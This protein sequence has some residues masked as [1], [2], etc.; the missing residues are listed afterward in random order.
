MGAARDEQCGAP[1]ARREAGGA[2]GGTSL[3]LHGVHVEFPYAPY[4]CQRAYMAKV[5]EALQAR[6]NALLESPT[7]TGKTLC[8][9]CAA[10]AWRETAKARLQLGRYGGDYR[11]RDAPESVRQKLRGASGIGGGDDDDDGNGNG[12][13]D[14]ASML[15]AIVA[16]GSGENGATK[17]VPRIIYLSRTHSQLTQVMR[18]LSVTA[19]ARSTRVLVMGA[20]QH[21]CIHPHVSQIASSAQQTVRCNAMTRSRRCEFYV[22]AEPHFQR[23]PHD[24]LDSGRPRDIE[25]MVAYGRE[26]R[27]CPYFL[28]RE[29]VHEA[30]LVLMPY[31]YV[32]DAKSRRA[33][34]MEFADDILIF[35]EAHN[36]ESACCEHSSFDLTALERRACLDALDHLAKNV[37]RYREAGGAGARELD[38]TD[39]LLVRDVVQAVDE[40][41]RAAAARPEGASGDGAA[42]FDAAMLRVRNVR[43]A[44]FRGSFIQ[45]FFQVPNFSEPVGRN[46][47]EVVV[48]AVELFIRTLSQARGVADIA[49][50]SGGAPHDYINN[51]N[52]AGDGDGGGDGDAAAVE[53]ALLQPHRLSQCVSALE[54]F[55]RVLQLAF[56]HDEHAVDRYFRI[57]VRADEAGAAGGG[58]GDAE[59]MAA[60]QATGTTH[61]D[62]FAALRRPQHGPRGSD[63][64][65]GGRGAPAGPVLSFWC[66]F[67]GLNVQSLARARSVI[68]TSGTLSPLDSFAA[69]MGIA[70]PVRLQNTHVIGAEQLDARVVRTGPSG[71]RL[72]GTYANRHNAE[73][74]RDLGMTLV[75][76]ARLAPGGMLVFFSS[77]GAMRVFIE[78]WQSAPRQQPQQPQQ[79]DIVRRSLWDRLNACKKVVVEPRA[80]NEFQAV[81][82]RYRKLVDESGGACLFAV[83]RG[84]IGEGLDFADQYG[85]AVV[86]AGVPFPSTTD[87][88]VVL[89][90]DFLDQDY[91]HQ[92]RQQRQQQREHRASEGG[93][94]VRGEDWYVQQS[95]RAANQAIGRVIR[96]CNDYGA[97]LLCDERYQARQRDLPR[98][99]LHLERRHDGDG[100]HGGA[101]AHA[102][103]AATRAATPAADSAGVRVCAHFGE[104][105]AGLGAFFRSD[106][107]KQLAR[108][109]RSTPASS[110]A[111]DGTAAGVPKRTRPDDC[112]TRAHADVSGVA[113][114]MRVFVADGGGGGEGEGDEGEGAVAKRSRTMVAK[115]ACS[116]ASTSPTPYSAALMARL[117]RHLG[118]ARYREMFGLLRQYRRVRKKEAVADETACEAEAA[119]LCAQ[120]RDLVGV[121]YFAE[122][123]MFLGRRPLGG[124]ERPEA[125][126]TEKEK[127]E[128]EEEGRAHE[129]RPSCVHSI[130]DAATVATTTTTTDSGEMCVFCLRASVEPRRAPCQHVGCLRCWRAALVFR[131]QCPRCGRRTTEH[132]LVG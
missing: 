80:A 116:S 21:L 57:C 18:E 51:N 86:L 100:D 44:V 115:T 49:D 108:Q 107:V 104:V 114:Q 98:W 82:L 79:P 87:P 96:H 39:V 109:T 36:L 117:Q 23:A 56:A 15:S 6:R 64:T 92:Q 7:G 67:A 58:G 95:V 89:K 90:R 43:G 74:A 65:D 3:T 60:P 5:V 14:A 2:G 34:N 69:E 38:V 31:N 110:S 112:V 30:E 126:T 91:H 20:R 66:L 1:V 121:E 75:N 32:L 101:G 68:L 41:V 25:D 123:E 12:N 103:S 4:D 127:E 99:L 59:A 113:E 88:K 63:Q 120:L 54:K 119:A 48:R 40:N 73:Y 28:S 33:L 128:E 9:L 10:L 24:L 131:Q 85:R 8:L 97:V 22:N 118:G 78:A 132:Q 94:A 37:P 13:G 105:A 27:M 11:E 17:G 77:Y 45:R 125:A 106:A 55:A 111:S 71:V 70:F 19:Y 81:L 35:D 130:D 122:L 50:G 46:N 102:A 83:C 62:R 124:D 53:R 61:R 72:L 93:R 16:E 52:D 42:D 29:A 84:R 129:A 47:C 76:V 26:R